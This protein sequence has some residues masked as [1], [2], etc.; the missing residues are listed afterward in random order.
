MEILDLKLPEA[1]CSRGCTRG[2]ACRTAEFKQNPYEIGTA[3]YNKAKH[4]GMFKT[5]LRIFKRFLLGY[6]DPNM[7]ELF[8]L[9]FHS[10]GA[11]LH[12]SISCPDSF[13]GETHTVT[14][15]THTATTICNIQ[16]VA[17][18]LIHRMHSG[19]A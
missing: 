7:S 5:G 11:N 18:L 8:L 9:G 19:H 12:N 1:H 10:E 2:S 13:A 3:G 16:V 17:R 4:A 6:S 15:D 14:Y